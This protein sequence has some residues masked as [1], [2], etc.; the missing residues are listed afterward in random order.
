MNATE[1]APSLSS[2]ASE[3]GDQSKT[4]N[5]LEE[6]VA[7][8]QFKKAPTLRRLL[9]Y[10]WEHR[11]EEVSEYAIATEALGRKA[12]FDPREDATVRVLVSR[13]RL[14]LRDFYESAE[15]AG[16]PTRIVIP[17]GSHQVQIIETPRLQTAEEPDPDL[18]PRTLRRE[19]R[20]RKVI[21]AQA[22]AIGLLVITCIGLRIQQNRAVENARQ[23][24]IR[25]LSPFWRFFL[26]DGKSTRVIL[27][28]PVLF[29]WGTG[30]LARDVNINDF[31]KIDESPWL[32]TLMRD[33]GSRSCPLDMYLLPTPSLY[34][35]LASILIRRDHS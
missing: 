31:T 34:Y 15:G 26:E 30:F 13:L 33:W 22:I 29:E 12:N 35:V 7:S 3:G 10:L 5:E 28:A 21:L 14:R 16:L 23:G 20:N 11:N 24:R 18:L 17:V 2:E 8:S 9:T 1:P 6:A 32:R 27:P 19:A 4:R 25:K